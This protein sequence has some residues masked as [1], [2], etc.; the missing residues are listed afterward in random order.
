MKAGD[1]DITGKKRID[2]T[3][4]TFKYRYAE[5]STCDTVVMI[6]VGTAMTI[7]DYELL[8]SDITSSDP[9]IVTIITD[10]NSGTLVK[11]RW[12]IYEEFY[13]N[14]MSSFTDIV[15]ACNG[16]TPKIIIGGHSASGRAIV[17][18]MAYNE[19]WSPKPDGFIGLNPFQMNEGVE[20]DASL[21]VLSWGFTTQTCRVSLDLSV[22]PQGIPWGVH[23]QL[24]DLQE[25]SA[26]ASRVKS[27]RQR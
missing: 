26:P 21:P 9:S 25:L 1:D 17:E 3:A 8:S 10:H 23:Y 15:P 24:T 22:L 4:G 18:A 2:S 14:I 27:R 6:G 19:T 7:E 20:I 11:L 13:R 12:Q 16:K 5:G